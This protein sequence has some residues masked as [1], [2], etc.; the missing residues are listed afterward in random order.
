MHFT[1]DTAGAWSNTHR[2]F[3][4]A[5]PS[6]S[7]APVPR[8][9]PPRLAGGGKDFSGLSL[10][11]ESTAPSCCRP[12][13][14]CV[15][16]CNLHL[17]ASQF[18]PMPYSKWTNP[19]GI[20]FLPCSGT[21]NPRQ[22]A[23]FSRRETLSLT[24]PSL[25]LKGVGRSLPLLSRCWVRASPALATPGCTLARE[26]PRVAG[27]SR[28]WQRRCSSRIRR[29]KGRVFQGAKRAVTSTERRGRSGDVARSPERQVAIRR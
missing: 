10:D 1:A 6:A 20:L 24:R 18:L 7:S 28:R 9:E 3:K 15:L 8:D 27:E 19:E 11:L 14:L 21:A 29:S 17:F 26:S 2:R 22:V 25:P 16:P 4:R 23:S 5:V 12:L 13:Q